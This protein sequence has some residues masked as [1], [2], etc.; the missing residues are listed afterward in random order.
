MS[1]RADPVLF[2][3][4]PLIR[5]LQKP[6]LIVTIIQYQLVI[7]GGSLSTLTDGQRAVHIADVIVRR[8]STTRGDGVSAG[9]AA[10][11]GCAADFRLL[12]QY[13]GILTILEAV[14]TYFKD[15]QL[16]TVSDCSVVGCYCQRRIVKTAEPALLMVSVFPLTV[17]TE[18][19]LTDQVSVIPWS[20]SKG[21][22]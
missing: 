18:V 8:L 2:E 5:F 16:V 14:V 9:G 12:G 3:G 22:V 4:Q 17:A 10:R 20:V 21:R 11:R 6:V 7:Q 15:R 19:L 1:A 13:T